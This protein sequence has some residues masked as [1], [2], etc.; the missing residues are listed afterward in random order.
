MNASEK[1]VFEMFKIEFGDFVNTNELILLID[2]FL[3]IEYKIIDIEK[4]FLQNVERAFFMKS[5]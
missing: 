5:L 2:D 3:N 4:P 1:R